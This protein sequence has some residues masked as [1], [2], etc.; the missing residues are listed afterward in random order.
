MGS[1]KNKRPEL[2]FNEISVSREEIEKSFHEM[3][4]SLKCGSCKYNFTDFSIEWGEAWREG[5]VEALRE[6]DV[7]ERDGPY[8]VKCENCGKRS[9]ICYF[10]KTAELVEE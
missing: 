2:K 9:L 5:R 6:C 4:K 1:R 8:K 10:S 3:V 7:V